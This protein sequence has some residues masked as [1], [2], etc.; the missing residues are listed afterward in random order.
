[1]DAEE[2]LRVLAEAAERFVNKAPNQKRLVSDRA[3]LLDAIMHAQLLLSVKS[4]RP[5][6]RAASPATP[7]RSKRRLLR[8]AK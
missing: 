8:L 3:A 4:P 1:M 6:G 7:K 5:K 2:A